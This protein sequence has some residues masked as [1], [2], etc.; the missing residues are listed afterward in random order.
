M[1]ILMAIKVLIYGILTNLPKHLLM[2]ISF[3]LMAIKIELNEVERKT[4]I[5]CLDFSV[6]I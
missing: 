5:Y 2:A 1:E 6:I 4:V 3:E